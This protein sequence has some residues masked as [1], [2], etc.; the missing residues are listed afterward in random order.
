[1]TPLEAQVRLSQ[2]INAKATW[3]DLAV[4][5]GQFIGASI[6]LADATIVCAASWVRMIVHQGGTR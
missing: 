5:V 1:M 4:K 2:M 6:L 3:D